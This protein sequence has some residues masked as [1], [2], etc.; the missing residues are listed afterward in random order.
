VGTAGAPKSQSTSRLLK[1]GEDRVFDICKGFWI[2]K[3]IGKVYCDGIQE[4][5]EFGWIFLDIIMIL[6]KIRQA[7]SSHS[8]GNTSLEGFFFVTTTLVSSFRFYIAQ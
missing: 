4:F 8:Y 3:K 1:G 6:V 7:E 2:S 5:L